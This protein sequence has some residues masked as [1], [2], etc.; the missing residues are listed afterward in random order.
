MSTVGQTQYLGLDLS[1]ST[2]P[3]QRGSTPLSSVHSLLKS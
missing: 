3:L 2:H 1:L